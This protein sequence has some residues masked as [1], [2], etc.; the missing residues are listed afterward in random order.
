MCNSN[1]LSNIII[2]FAKTV[3]DMIDQYC[4]GFSDSVLHKDILSPAD[5]Q[6]IFGLTGGN[7]SHVS[8]SLDQV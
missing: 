7:I 4:P 5:L 2:E 6:N 1:L 3:F 8:M